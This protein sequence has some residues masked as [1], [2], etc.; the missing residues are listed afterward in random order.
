MKWTKP[1]E[2]TPRCAVGDRILVVLREKEN[3]KWVRRL[4][5]LEAQED[6]WRSLD[7]FYVGYSPDDAELWAHERDVV[8]CL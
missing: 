5:I 7:D 6:G 8:R 2:E 3:G 4:A 1:S